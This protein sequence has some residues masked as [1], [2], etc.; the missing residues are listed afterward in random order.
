MTDSTDNTN[1]KKREALKLRFQKNAIPTEQDFA[2]L[3]DAPLN[4]S[5]DG[6]FKRPGQ[7]LSVVAVE[8]PDRCVL[9]LHDFGAETPSWSLCLTPEDPLDPTKRFPGLGMND[10]AGNTR[11]FLD[12]AGELSVVTLR[13][14]KADIHSLTA[15]SAT[16]TAEVSAE[17][18]VASRV[19]SSGD[20]LALELKDAGSG[21][22]PALV[23]GHARLPVGGGPPCLMIGAKSG[24]NGSP[25]VLDDPQVAWTEASGE[26]QAALRF[27]AG[28]SAYWEA[29]TSLKAGAPIS[30]QAFELSYFDKDGQQVNGPRLTLDK[31][32]SM[33]VGAV[34]ANTVHAEIELTAKSAT[35]S[36]NLNVARI[37]STNNGLEINVQ[38][39]DVRICFKGGY[40]AFQADGNLVRYTYPVIK[41]N[42]VV[43]GPTVLF[44]LYEGG[45]QG[46]GRGNTGWI[47]KGDKAFRFVFLRDDI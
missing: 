38:E 25:L 36:G 3:I 45:G 15:N 4:Q 10:A 14:L 44:A 11:L 30:E 34:N 5:D 37:E 28:F 35:V 24:Q 29:R 31:S 16:V 20:S 22:A 32:G 6:V 41:D 33:T 43:S 21:N 7:P 46:L 8:S 18:L 9:Q 39:K 26:R 12:G 19:A 27:G 17:S 2:D 13:A 1:V 23:L 42:K 40:W 47:Q